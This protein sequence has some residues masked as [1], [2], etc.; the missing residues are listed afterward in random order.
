[1]VV[2][3]G[4]AGFIGSAIVHRLG[5]RYTLVGLDRDG[6]PAPPAPAVAIKLDSWSSDWLSPH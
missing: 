1:M 5:D 3:T 2:I 4:A 6:V